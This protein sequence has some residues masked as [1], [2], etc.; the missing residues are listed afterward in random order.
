MPPLQGQDL[1]IFQLDAALAAGRDREDAGLD[2]VPAHV[3]QQG[4]VAP[5]PDDLLVDSAGLVG[6]EHLR[7]YGLPVHP[8]HEPADRRAGRQR[9]DVGALGLPVVLVDEDLVHAGGGDLV[10]YGDGHPMIADSEPDRFRGRA[11]GPGRLRD[12]DTVGPRGG[13]GGQQEQNPQQGEQIPV[14]LHGA[15]LYLFSHKD[16]KTR[17]IFLFFSHE[18]TKTRR[19]F[20]F[21]HTKTQRHKIF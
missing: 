20:Y 15:S 2:G 11:W 19:I 16:T 18:D 5:A 7:L 13:S 12:D 14:S 4:R 6:G 21:S 10:V 3:F 1:G 17:R 8:H 9:E